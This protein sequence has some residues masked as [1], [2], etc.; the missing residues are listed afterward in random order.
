MSHELL[1][2]SRRLYAC[3]TTCVDHCSE[4]RCVG[5]PGVAACVGRSCGG[6]REL[7]YSRLD[8]A[9]DSKLI[10]VG[11]DRFDHDLEPAHHCSRADHH[12]HRSDSPKRSL[13]A[14]RCGYV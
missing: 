10:D 5:C 6:L 7:G 14:G 3:G 1:T 11:C 9:S 4:S 13:G 2:P 12:I 8:D